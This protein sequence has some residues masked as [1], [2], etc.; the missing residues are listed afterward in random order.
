MSAAGKDAALKRLL[1]P[2]VSAV[3]LLIPVVVWLISTHSPLEYFTHAVPPGQR[4]YILSKLCGLLALALFWLQCMTALARSAPAVRGF[5][6]LTRRQHVMLGVTTFVLV[7][8][9]LGLFI[10]ASSI[11]TH[12]FALPLL[13]PKFDQGFYSS[14]ISLGAIAFW[15]LLAVLVAGILR[16]RGF[17]VWRWLHRASLLVFALG[18]LH[19]LVIG[20]E[21]RFG[22]MKY[23]Y[24]FIGLSLAAAVGSWM[25]LTISARLRARGVTP[26][27]AAVVTIPSA[28][29]T[30]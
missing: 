26:Q 30:K 27:N 9:H 22:L 2:A 18:F 5:F 14:F 25:W 1:V 23:I 8:T 12:H 7:L 3:T 6:S 20:S 21:T 16:A 13:V 10:A 17:Q 4:V 24:A 11:R 28:V 29:E 19:G 15:I